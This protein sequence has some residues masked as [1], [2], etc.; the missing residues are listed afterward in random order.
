MLTSPYPQ[1]AFSERVQVPVMNISE[2]GAEKVVAWAAASLIKHYL[3]LAWIGREFHG[4]IEKEEFRRLV[5]RKLAVGADAFP[6]SYEGLKELRDLLLPL[7]KPHGY[8]GPLNKA[9]DP[10]GDQIRFDGAKMSLPEANELVKR[11]I[12]PLLFD[13]KRSGDDKGE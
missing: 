11:H 2:Q 6:A 4:E 3:D 12:I 1:L 9:R 8:Y 7:A 10:K 13:R 5:K